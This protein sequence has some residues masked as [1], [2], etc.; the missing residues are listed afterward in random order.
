MTSVGIKF[1]NSEEGA[2]L[3]SHK[4]E[5]MAICTE[6]RSFHVANVYSLFLYTRSVRRLLPRRNKKDI[7]LIWK[8]SYSPKIIAHHLQ[9]PIYGSNLSA[10]QHMNG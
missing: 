4:I 6:E 9:L 10:H 8:N 5:I 3:P 2:E 1:C 7:I